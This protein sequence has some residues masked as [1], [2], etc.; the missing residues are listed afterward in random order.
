MT[1]L[2]AEAGERRTLDCF[3]RRAAW[4]FAQAHGRRQR[5]VSPARLEA[6]VPAP[7]SPAL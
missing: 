7:L 4:R 2:T 5:L 1:S 3:R 6:R